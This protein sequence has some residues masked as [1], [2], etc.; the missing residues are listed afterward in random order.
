[1]Q[2]AL[3]RY[4][5]ALWGWAARLAS[6][7]EGE[8]GGRT[9]RSAENAVEW[10]IFLSPLRHP[11]SSSPISFAVVDS[12][13]RQ[14]SRVPSRHQFFWAPRRI[15]DHS[16]HTVA[17]QDIIL[18][19]TSECRVILSSR[20]RWKLQRYSKLKFCGGIYCYNGGRADANAFTV[21]SSFVV[22]W[23]SLT[24]IVPSFRYP[25]HLLFSAETK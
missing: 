10:H 24:P 14:S 7:R 25:F 2:P 19:G 3:R 8:R 20:T 4:P 6:G 23:R 17:L 5:L 11:H 22:R 1:M 13:R 9:R 21:L 16:L 18:T 12:V 15:F